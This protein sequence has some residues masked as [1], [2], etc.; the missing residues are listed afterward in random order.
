MIYCQAQVDFR[1]DFTFSASLE[2]FEKLI[3][4]E[5]SKILG[6]KYGKLVFT[7]RNVSQ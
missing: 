7:Q 3:S 6:G 5:V 4:S 2:S 1:V